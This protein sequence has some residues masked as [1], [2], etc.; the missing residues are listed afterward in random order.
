MKNTNLIEK[1]EITK[2]PSRGA[3]AGDGVLRIVDSINNE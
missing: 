1:I 3:R 2:S